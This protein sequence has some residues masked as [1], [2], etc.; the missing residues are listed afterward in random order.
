MIDATAEMLDGANFDGIL[1]LKEYLLSR[2]EDFLRGLAER[3]LI[4]G[5]GRKLAVADRPRIEAIVKEARMDGYKFH[6][7]IQA[8][9]DSQSFRTR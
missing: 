4:Y 9:V 5:S 1:G 6:R 8:V 7:L 2:K 3:L